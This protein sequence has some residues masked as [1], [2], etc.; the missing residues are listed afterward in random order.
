MPSSRIIDLSAL[1]AIEDAAKLW[2]GADKEDGT[3]G[4]Y[5]L[6]VTQLRTFVPGLKGSY[7][8]TTNTPALTNSTGLSGQAYVVNAQASA[9][10]RDFG[11]GSITF[12]ANVAG[13]LYHNGTAYQF[14]SATPSN[15][16]VVMP[17][18]YPAVNGAPT[19]TEA[20]IYCQTNSVVGPTLLV[21]AGSGTNSEPDYAWYIDRLGAA[22][23]VVSADSS[24]VP[25]AAPVYSTLSFPSHG[26][27]ASDVGKALCRGALFD[28]TSASSYFSHILISITDTNT[29]VVAGPG[30]D[31]TL[32]VSL[33]DGGSLYNIGTSGAF[34]Y[35][36][37]S[38]SKYK[39]DKQADSDAS[40][41]AVLELFSVGATTFVAR[42]K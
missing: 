1:S 30:K 28:D 15:N 20:I 4:S 13:I 32:P 7:N 25:E 31:V 22:I 5:K 41:S 40:V 10:S 8:Q 3:A 38:A 12:P 27:T 21:Y 18:A 19:T 26:R 39:A 9:V 35:W 29:L 33:L 17:Q 11:S 37:L 2:F 14:W 36:D 16:V 24:V 42:V 23:R 34:V 6:N